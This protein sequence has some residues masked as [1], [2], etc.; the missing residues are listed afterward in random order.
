MNG[1]CD[2]PL[3][4]SSDSSYSRGAASESSAL[5][6]AG[7]SAMKSNA[8]GEADFIAA[9]FPVPNAEIADRLLEL[10]VPHDPTR[11]ASEDVA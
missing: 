5:T 7:T 6:S 11:H 1:R 10:L 3:P 2:M 8:V 4:R 9:L